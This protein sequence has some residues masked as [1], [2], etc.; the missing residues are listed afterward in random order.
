MAEFHENH[1]QDEVDHLTL[2]RGAYLAKDRDAFMRY[3]VLV[4][5]PDQNP[6]TDPANPGIA[7]LGTAQHTSILHRSD[8]ARTKAENDALI[9]EN[10]GALASLTK[11]TILTLVTCAIGALVQ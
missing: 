6:T 10:K 7:A 1:L 8:R 11:D 4:T 3:P 9:D 2:Q 5:A